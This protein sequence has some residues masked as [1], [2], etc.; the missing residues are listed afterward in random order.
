MIIYEVNWDEDYI[1]C[2]RSWHGTQKEAKAK[3]KE[4]SNESPTFTKHKIPEKKT[5]FIFWLNDNFQTD[6]G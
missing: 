1:G 3:M 6:N 5:D 4:H 2:V